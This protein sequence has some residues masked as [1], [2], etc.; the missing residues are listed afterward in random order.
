M[1]NLNIDTKVLDADIEDNYNSLFGKV[2]VSK[3]LEPQLRSL[4]KDLVIRT[5]QIKIINNVVNPPKDEKK[6]GQ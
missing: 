1:F 3:E 6:D 4:V 5:Y 2:E